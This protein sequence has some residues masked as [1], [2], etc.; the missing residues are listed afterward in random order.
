MATTNLNCLSYVIVVYVKSTI[1]IFLIVQLI[2]YSY[3][4]GASNFILQVLNFYLLNEE[5]SLSFLFNDYHFLKL[6]T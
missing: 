6:I 3:C 5:F 1:P 2:S 4:D